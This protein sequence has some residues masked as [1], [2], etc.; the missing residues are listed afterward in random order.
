MHVIFQLY[1]KHFAEAKDQYTL[2]RVKWIEKPCNNVT[3]TI[4]KREDVCWGAGGESKQMKGLIGLPVDRQ[5]ERI[6]VCLAEMRNG[7]PSFVKY[8]W[9]TYTES[10]SLVLLTQ[11]LV[12]SVTFVATMILFRWT[13]WFSGFNSLIQFNLFHNLELHGVLPNCHL[14]YEKVLASTNF[15]QTNMKK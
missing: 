1:E 15:L 12:Y 11:K 8:I 4:S 2:N 5:M 6:F 10:C 9:P 14:G 13:I 3:A 7:L